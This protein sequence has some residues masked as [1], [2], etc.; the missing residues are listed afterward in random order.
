MLGVTVRSISE[1]PD[2][3]NRLARRRPV[4]LLAISCAAVLAWTVGQALAQGANDLPERLRWNLVGA[5]I[6][7]FMINPPIAL[8]YM[9]GLNT[10]PVHAHAAFFGV[11]GMLGLGLTLMCPRAL[12]A[13]REW[14]EG[15][16]RFSFWAMNAGLMAMILLSLLPVGLLQTVASVKHG[17]WYA[18]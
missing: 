3:V 7:G 18:R 11:Y 2:V 17:Y 12:Q 5:G 9:Q 16:L 1:G 4:G 13:D 8:F 15:L 14:K 6:F 10:T